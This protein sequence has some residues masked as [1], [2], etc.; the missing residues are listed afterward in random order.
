MLKE[1]ALDEFRNS[2]LLW[3]IN[4]TLHLFGVC[5]AMEMSD[6][7]KAVRMYPARCKFRGFDTASNDEGY[8]KVSKYMEQNAADLV[9][10]CAE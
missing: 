6:D 5:I 10:D 9:K 7:G 4:Q 3:F 2:G 1:M 8:L